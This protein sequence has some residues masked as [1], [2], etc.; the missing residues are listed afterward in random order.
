MLS[1]SR[2]KG[3]NTVC[4]HGVDKVEFISLPFQ[5]LSTNRHSLFSASVQVNVW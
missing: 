4:L 5:Y 3:K 1:E 2:A